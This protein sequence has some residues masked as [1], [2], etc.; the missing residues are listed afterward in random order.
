MLIG[1]TDAEAEAGGGLV[2]KSCPTLATP[3][4]VVCQAPLSMG[5]LQAGVLE[6]VVISFS[7]GSFRPRNRTQVSCTAS[8]L[9]PTEL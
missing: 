6:W 8:R 3:W 7:R 2:T 1:R 4:G 5:I 9:L